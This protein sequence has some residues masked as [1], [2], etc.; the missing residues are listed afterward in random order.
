MLIAL[1]LAMQLAIKVVKVGRKTIQD[2]ALSIYEITLTKANKGINSCSD[3]CAIVKIKT[4][5]LSALCA[6]NLISNFI[7]KCITIIVKT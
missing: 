5:L 1:Q 7:N 4:C 3:L 6:Q 2:G